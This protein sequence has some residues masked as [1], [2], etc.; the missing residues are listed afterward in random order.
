MSTTPRDFVGYGK[1]YPQIG[2]PNGARI[3]VSMVV[4]FEEGSERTPLNDDPVAESGGEAFPV[5]PG[6][7]S[8]IHESLYDYG[9]R[10]GF[11]RLLDILDRHDV[12]ATFFCCGMA[13]EMNPEAAR[14]ITARGHEPASHGYRW[15]FGN[16]WSRDDEREEI[17][18]AVEAIERTTGEHPKG[19]FGLGSS[20]YTREL[21]MEEGGF[22]YDCNSFADDLPYFVE[23]EGKKW[24]V[25]PYDLVTNDGPFWRAPGYSRPADFFRQLKSAFDCLYAEG[26]THPKMMS[27]GLH[28]RM[29]GRPGRATAVDNFIRYAKGFPGVWFARR[30]DIA[31]WWLEH[32]GH[33]PALPMRTLGDGG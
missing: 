2:W 8:L 7:R 29:S 19:W 3:A 22:V 15:V 21:L 33:L 24:P 12:K 18:M 5:P 27:V 9:G 6:Q 20:G 13:L 16:V 30:I 17:R 4:N 28:M 31:R 32:Y 14:E 26:A 23:V 11:W 10:A 25:L 1:D